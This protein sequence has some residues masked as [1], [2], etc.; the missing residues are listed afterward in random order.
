MSCEATTLL[1]KGALGSEGEGL[2]GHTAYS[3]CT[4]PRLPLF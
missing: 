2:L 1:G 4:L 3:L